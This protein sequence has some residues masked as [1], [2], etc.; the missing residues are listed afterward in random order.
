[1]IEEEAPESIKALAWTPNNTTSTKSNDKGVI[2][3][4]VNE[5]KQKKQKKN[6]TKTKQKKQKKKQKNKKT[7]KQKQIK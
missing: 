1:M 7:K 3:A 2:E 4:S 6:K 5:K